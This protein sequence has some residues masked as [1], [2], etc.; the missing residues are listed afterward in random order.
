MLNLRNGVN[1][2]RCFFFYLSL[3]LFFEKKFWIN[4]SKMHS[5]FIETY[6]CIEWWK[7]VFVEKGYDCLATNDGGTILLSHLNAGPVSE[8]VAKY[9]PSVVGDVN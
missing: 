8:S 6:H 2:L 3:H 5:F 9:A 4:N 1:I 7:I